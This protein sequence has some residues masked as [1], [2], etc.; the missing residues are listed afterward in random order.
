MIRAAVAISTQENTKAAAVEA[1]QQVSAALS[2]SADWCVAFATSEHEAAAPAMIETLSQALGTPYVVGCSASGV[3]AGGR[4]HEAGPALGVLA[5]ASDQLR[6]TPFLFRDEGDRGM[7]AGVRLGQRLLSSRDSNDL[8]VVWPDPFHVRPDRL[9]QGLDAVLGGIPVLGGASSAAPGLARTFQFC[10]SE[11]GG[12]GVSGVRF[13]GDFRYVVGVT[14][15]CRP[16]GEPL[17]VTRAHDNM[18]LELDGRPPLEALRERAP[19]G[20]MDDLESAFNWL[21][22]G[23]LPDPDVPR[24]DPGQYLVRNIVASD[25]DTGVLAIP[26]NLEEGQYIVFVHRDAQSAREDLL[27]VVEQVSP[28]RTGLDY[29]FGLYFNCLARGRSLYH[30]RDVDA[31]LLA[32]ALPDVPLLG[33]FCNAELG[34]LKGQ[35]QLFTYTGVLVLIAE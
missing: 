27:R 35:N 11:S 21:F 32:E 20:L 24:I 26:D 9:L 16:L 30:E 7:T 2:G 14:Q 19:Q 13:G 10:G 8:L 22:V 6:A 17:R 28:R 3:L 25:P 12:A 1:A 4:E 5:V 31:S 29:R 18:I 23:L 15:G 34:P 33:L